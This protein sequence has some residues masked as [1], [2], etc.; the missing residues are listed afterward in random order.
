MSR[1]LSPVIDWLNKYQGLPSWFNAVFT[2]FV[3]IFA[4]KELI[5]KRRPFI[6]I[7]IQVALNP[8]KTKGGWLFFALLKNKGTYPGIVRVTKTLMKIGDEEYPD[9]VN[10]EFILSPEEEKKS[11]LIGSIYKN[12]VDKIIGHKYRSNRV[13][14]SIEITSRAIGEKKMKYK[15]EFVYEVNV[16]GEKPDIILLSEKMV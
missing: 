9:K 11:A 8:D 10:N 15:S 6:D 13:E 12:G 5:L 14:I 4:Y 1:F 16:V 2:L 3:L 7:E